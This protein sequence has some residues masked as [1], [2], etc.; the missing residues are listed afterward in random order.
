MD[1]LT[2]NPTADIHYRQQ[3]CRETQGRISVIDILL[4][5]LMCAPRLLN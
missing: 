5:R 3:A 2:G 1:L 4:R